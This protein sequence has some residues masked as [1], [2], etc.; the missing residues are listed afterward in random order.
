M[1]QNLALSIL[2]LLVGFS[3][4]SLAEWKKVGTL[5]DGGNSYVDFD[6]VKVSGGYV[7]F[8]RLDDFRQPIDGISS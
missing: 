3:T 5:A 2:I 4:E 1:K 6:R 7:Y 8:W